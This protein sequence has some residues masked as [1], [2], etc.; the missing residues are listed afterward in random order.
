[1]RI[2]HI[3]ISA[4]LLASL[5]LA[6][7]GGGGDSSSGGGII[8]TAAAAELNTSSTA[9]SLDPALQG[10]WVSATA[11]HVAG[12][13]CSITSDNQA[14][15]RFTFAFSGTGY[16]AK[17]EKCALDQTGKIGTF[18]QF[19][20]DDGTHST[21]PVFLSADNRQ[22]SALDLRYFDENRRAVVVYLGYNIAGSELRVTRT[23]GTADGSTPSRRENG[24][25][26]FQLVYL[27]Q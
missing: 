25:E 13:K 14:E 24:T 26:P 3:A 8:S 7:C 18:V 6:G 5:A 20:L 22:Y 17:A 21:G 16:S 19:G 10:T 15:V 2:S 1:M 4:A 27:K 23:L 9:T 11:G 12:S